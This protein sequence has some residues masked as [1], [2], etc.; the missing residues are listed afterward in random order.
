VIGPGRFYSGVGGV[1]SRL[2]STSRWLFAP[3]GNGINRT[4][5]VRRLVQAGFTLTCIVIG[6]QFT[7]FV[8]AAQRGEMPLPDRPAGVE[9]FLPI[10]GLMGLKDWWHAGELNAFHPAASALLVIF[11]A[12]A[13]LL[14]KGFCSWVC[15]VGFFSEALAWM[16]RQLY[17][18]NYRIYTPLDY[19]LR[20]L[21]WALLG[22]FVH[23]IW[24]MPALGLRAFLESPYNRVADV[25]MGLFFT[26]M[27]ATA[28]T[29]LVLL[30]VLSTFVNGAWCRYL[31]P[32]GALLGAVSW[33]SP[34]R[35]RRDPISCIDCRKC[36]AVCMARLPVSQT[37]HVLSPECTGCMDCI[38]ACPVDDALVLKT[39][40]RKIP[41][42]AFAVGLVLLF[43]GG[44]M[45]ARVGGSWDNSISDQEY[46]GRIQSIDDPSYGHPGSAGYGGD[47]G[48]AHR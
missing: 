11:L 5:R 2:R 43:L 18:R 15:P 44:Y 40:P 9:G 48:D 28:I 23:A 27:G 46:I 33:M 41:V 22:F 17:G 8:T 36:D 29:V 37:S 19:L 45:S 30:A 31:C 7:R 38:A 47:S 25:K 35:V 4:W 16:G 20:G 24:T 12:M 34:T 14:R 39:G 3:I 26:Q 1:Q 32:Y 10:S 13:V 42:S 21:K 6:I